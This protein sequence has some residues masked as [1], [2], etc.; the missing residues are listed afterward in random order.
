MLE[1]DGAESGL[2]FLRSSHAE[3]QP[4]DPQPDLGVLG[5]LDN[6]SLKDGQR[7]DGLP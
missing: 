5:I 2:G 7:F 3:L 1:Q 6:D 4:R